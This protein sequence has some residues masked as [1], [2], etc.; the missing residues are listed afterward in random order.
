MK[1]TKLDYIRAY[2]S[3]LARL[4]D[5]RSLSRMAHITDDTPLGV[6]K[7]WVLLTIAWLRWRVHEIQDRAK[8]EGGEA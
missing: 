6:R 7:A 1:L 3:P 8:R 5:V 4:R 2:M